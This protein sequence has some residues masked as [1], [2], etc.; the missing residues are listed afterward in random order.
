[1]LVSILLEPHLHLADYQFDSNMLFVPAVIL[2]LLLTV[3]YTSP[4]FEPPIPILNPL[5]PNAYPASPFSWTGSDSSRDSVNLQSPGDQATAPL[6]LPFSPQ[7]LA[8]LPDI[9]FTILDNQATNPVSPP[10]QH[11]RYLPNLGST[12]FAKHPTEDTTLLSYI[13]TTHAAYQSTE[14]FRCSNTENGDITFACCDESQFCNDCKS[15]LSPRSYA[16]I[17]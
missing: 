3:A 9:G 10:P 14:C 17:A 8:Y 6:S 7:P 4:L 16:P 2:T 5:P 1:M 12:F 15:L 13:Y 11:P